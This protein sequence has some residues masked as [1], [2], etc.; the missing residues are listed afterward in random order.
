MNKKRAKLNFVLTGLILILAI[1][2]CFVQFKLPFSN[3]NFKGFLGAINATSDISECNTAVYE[4]TDKNATNEQINQTVIK[5]R[6][7]LDDQGFIGSKVYRQGNYIKAE[8]ESS[9][10]SSTIL[11]IIGDS[12]TFYISATD[13]ETITEKEL[14]DN[15]IIGTDIVKAYSTKQYNLNKEYNGVTIKFNADG[16]KKLKELTKK[17][18]A[19]E[20]SS[21]YFYID[22]QKST[23]L[24]VE[25]SNDDFLSFYSEGY[26]Q[27]TAKEYALQI[28]MSST[29]VSL[30]IVSN[31]ISTAVMG[32]NLATFLIILSIIFVIAC[33]IALPLIYGRFGILACLSILF[34]F[35]LNIFFLQA[36]PFTTTSTGT[37]LGMWLGM[38]LLIVCHILF[39]NKIKSEFKVLHKVP[40]A[41][42]TGYKK[43][44][45]NILD[46]CVLTI[47]GALTLSLW[48]I[49]FVST[50][51]IGLSIS[52]IIALFNSIYL[53]KEFIT[54]YINIDYK[55]YKKLKLTKGE[56]NEQ[57]N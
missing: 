7:I 46:L 16:T 27:D 55:N 11:A 48:K 1:I 50:F 57:E 3:N 51:A 56:K 2:L 6:E 14:G 10:T 31:N 4:I 26:S 47:I 19:T 43:S 49:P 13:K 38:A 44:W 32:N 45:L 35:V 24:K 15:D 39:L 21:V 36:L 18:A 29:G 8:V 9:S 12:K 23:S 52:S 25:E 34:A 53:F 28:L 41:V 33:L 20:S 42:K 30:D 5:M 17:A 54:W 22:G 37:V 40:L